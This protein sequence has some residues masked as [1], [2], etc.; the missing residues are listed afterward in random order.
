MLFDL[1]SLVQNC[2]I[3][4][5]P[6]LLSRLRFLESIASGMGCEKCIIILWW[7]QAG[8]RAKLIFV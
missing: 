8:T 6:N 3:N 4:T 2:H 7:V 5:V 1:Y